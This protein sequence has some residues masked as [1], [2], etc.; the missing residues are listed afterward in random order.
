M[1]QFILIWNGSLGLSLTPGASAHGAPAGTN[2]T[3]ARNKCDDAGVARGTSSPVGDRARV[4]VAVRVGA[5]SRRLNVNE[6]IRH[7]TFL[8]F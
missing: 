3:T 1:R 4:R 8:V 2:S 7:F 5:R 6:T